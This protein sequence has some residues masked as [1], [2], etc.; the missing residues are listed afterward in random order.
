MSG[1]TLASGITASSITSLG[2][3]TGLSVN[4]TLNVQNGNS[5]DFGTVTNNN[6]RGQIAA[7]ESNDQHLI[8]ATSGGEDIA[9]RDG[10]LNG[11]T[12]MIIKGDGNVHQLIMEL[13]TRL[14]IFW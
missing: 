3:L 12:N 7:T 5:L 4:G 1:T 11:T 9:F 14:Q 10:G 2:T 13:L 8:I 6:I